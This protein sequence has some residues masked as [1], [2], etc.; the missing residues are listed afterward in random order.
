MVTSVVPPY[1]W[2]VT[3]VRK[4]V[5]KCSIW[6][7]V[8]NK[9]NS[10]VPLP[11]ENSVFELVST[12]NDH[13]KMLVLSLCCVF[14]PKLTEAPLFKEVPNQDLPVLLWVVHMP[15]ALAICC[16]GLGL[17]LEMLAEQTWCVFNVPISFTQAGQ[18]REH[19]STHSVT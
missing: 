5:E 3:G 19:C 2:V 7:E 9:A 6:R 13:W 4:M 8:T 11:P 15:F 1:D 14:K 18:R 12:L 10:S 17:H 16:L